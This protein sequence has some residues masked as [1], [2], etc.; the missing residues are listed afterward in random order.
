MDII[1]N[2][3]HIWC[4]PS[5]TS[6]VLA[7]TNIVLTLLPQNISVAP[8][9]TPNKSSL[10]VR[11]LALVLVLNIY[12]KPKGYHGTNGVTIYAV[13]RCVVMTGMVF[14][15]LLNRIIPSTGCDSTLSWHMHF[16]TLHFTHLI[17]P[18]FQLLYDAKCS[19]IDVAPE[20]LCSTELNFLSLQWHH[21]ERDGVSNHQPHDC[22]LNCFS[23]RSMKT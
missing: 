22:L 9:H 23:G 20:C 8:F 21:N 2:R 15:E 6:T 7:S 16:F 11:I 17:P 10:H 18:I 4:I 19:V 3:L 14:V 13:P 5:N 1:S 12:V